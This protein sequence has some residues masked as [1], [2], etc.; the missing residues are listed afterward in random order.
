[1]INVTEYISGGLPRTDIT[2]TRGD[3]ANLVMPVYKVDADGSRA[4]YSVTG[5]DTVAVQVRKSPV[6]NS[7]I[8]PAVVIVG[9]VTVTDGVPNWSISSANS[10]IDVGT[11]YWDAQIT[12][13]G[14]VYTF[15][16]GQFIIV[17]E[18][19]V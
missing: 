5:A 6:T 17:P 13:G 11:Y 14:Q 16:S 4:P 19:T 3:N 9:T 15:Y 10:T 18:V 8:T 2:L 1:M 12:T 7:T